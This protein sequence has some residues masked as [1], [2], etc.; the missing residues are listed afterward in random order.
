MEQLT[1]DKRRRVLRW[2]ERAFDQELKSKGPAARTMTV[3][4]LNNRLL[5]LTNRTF[6]VSDFGATSLRELLAALAPEIQVSGH[7]NS[8]LVQLRQRETDGGVFVP[9]T[10]DSEVPPVL[11]CERLACHQYLHAGGL[12]VVDM[13][14]NIGAAAIGSDKAISAICVEEFDPPTW[15]CS[16]NPIQRTANAPT[17][18]TGR[19]LAQRAAPSALAERAYLLRWM[20]GGSSF[21]LRLVRW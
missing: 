2:I 11:T 21:I 5:K 10:D 18:L 3:A 15:H 12:G 8:Q 7:H 19:S 17:R 14:K 6:K 1:G 20:S 13:H 4:V 9:G 16:F